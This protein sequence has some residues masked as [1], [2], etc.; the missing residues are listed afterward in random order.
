MSDT[1]IRQAIQMIESQDLTH[2]SD[3]HD[4]VTLAALKSALAAPL[5]DEQIERLRE[6]TFSTNNPFCPVDSKS[7]RKA[8]RAYE[9]AIKG[10]AT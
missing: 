5:T 1:V 10:G 3:A 4:R 8:I 7:M 9:A 6:K 2:W